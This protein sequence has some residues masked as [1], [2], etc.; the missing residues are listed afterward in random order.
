MFVHD[1]Y[2]FYRHVTSKSASSLILFEYK[3]KVRQRGTLISAGW[4][5]GPR[6]HNRLARRTYKQ[7]KTRLRNAEVVSSSLTRGTQIFSRTSVPTC[8]T[9]PQK[10][11]STWQKYQKLCWCSPYIY[12]Y[13]YKIYFALHYIPIRKLHTLFWVTFPSQWSTIVQQ[14]SDIV[15]QYL[16]FIS[17]LISSES[18]SIWAY[19]QILN[20]QMEM[21]H[22]KT[23]SFLQN[24]ISLLLG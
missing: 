15:Q 12:I 24:Y 19:S 18:L 14:Y 6:W 21:G 13:A 23:F 1:V 9:R 20:Y 16:N 17:K 10:Y 4:F 5:H 22:W 8:L 2:I 3:R 11:K 7:Y